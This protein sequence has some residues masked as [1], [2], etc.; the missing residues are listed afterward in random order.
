VFDDPNKMINETTNDTK[1]NKIEKVM[2]TIGADEALIDKNGEMSDYRG[3]YD[4]ANDSS[5]DDEGND[6]ST[7]NADAVLI[8]NNE[9]ESAYKSHYSLTNDSSVNANSNEGTKGTKGT[10]Y[11]D[12]ATAND[13][14]ETKT[15]NKAR[16]MQDEPMPPIDKVEKCDAKAG[17]DGYH[18]A[19]CSHSHITPNVGMIA[20]N[21]ASKHQSGREAATSDSEAKGDLDGDFYQD[22]PVA[23]HFVASAD[24][25]PCPVLNESD[26]AK[27]VAQVKIK[28]G[29]QVKIKSRF[30]TNDPPANLMAYK[31]GSKGTW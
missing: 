23:D 5:I 11:N 3:H 6:A 10:S 27:D 26:N 2:L 30:H 24:L 15:G 12:T 31:L 16:P 4:D 25:L 13:E 28:D 29:A 14:A 9:E 20:N 19:K 21:G 22:H 17:N 18:D 7:I 8:D 1:N